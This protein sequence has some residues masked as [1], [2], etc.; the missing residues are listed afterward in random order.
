MT[1]SDEVVERLTVWPLIHSLLVQFAP[2][3]AKAEAATTFEERIAIING[4]SAHIA[5]KVEQHIDARATAEKI[6][7]ELEAG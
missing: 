5:V 7:A 6:R 1:H 2:R 4:V 3:I